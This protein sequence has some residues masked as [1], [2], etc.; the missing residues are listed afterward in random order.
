[1][2]DGLPLLN[3]DGS[4]AEVLALNKNMKQQ[5]LYFDSEYNRFTNSKKPHEPDVTHWMPLPLTPNE[6]PQPQSAITDV[7]IEEAGREAI[8]HI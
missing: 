8:S 2:K 4:W 1:M 5:V 7:E 3:N 6:T